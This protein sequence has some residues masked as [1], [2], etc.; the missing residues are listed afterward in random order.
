[1]RPGWEDFLQEPVLG[2]LDEIERG[3]RQ[4]R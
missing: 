2:E 1:L 3:Q 4:G